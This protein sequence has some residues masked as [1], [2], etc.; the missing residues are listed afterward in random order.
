MLSIMN[1][2]DLCL[3]L[4]LC[5]LYKIQNQIYQHMVPWLS[6]DFDFNTYTFFDVHA[7]A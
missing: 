7:I 6:V 3:L 4:P 2:I 1:E 5:V